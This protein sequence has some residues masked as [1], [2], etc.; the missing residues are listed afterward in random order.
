MMKS[1]HITYAAMDDDIQSHDQCCND[2][3]EKEQAQYK[4][5]EP[6]EEEDDDEG[7]THHSVSDCHLR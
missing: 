1:S 7:R 4:A 6:A 5:E 2:E 3:T